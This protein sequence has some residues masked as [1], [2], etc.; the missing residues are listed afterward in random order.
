MKNIIYDNLVKS[1][2]EKRKQLAILV[3]PDKFDS[4]ESKS[5]LE[6]IPEETTHIFIG[7]ST[8]ANGQ[9][10]QT[11]NAFKEETS[12][13]IILFPGDYSQITKEADGI[14]FLSLLSGNNPEYLIGQQIKSIPKIINT[15]LQI[16]PTAYILIDGGKQSAVSK[17]TN[18]TAL[19]QDNIEQIVHTALAGEFL[20]YK[21]IYLEAGSGAINP[22]SA[23][24]ISAVK[25][26]ITIPLVVGGGIR[27]QSQKDQAF[28][29]GADMV[30]MGTI[31]E[32]RR[33]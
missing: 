28:I 16:L 26:I 29:A 14:L 5:F 10:E 27:S 9:T 7:G 12:L 18:T 11:V 15:S 31:Y 33:N 30:V 17:A 19:S 23:E 20:G 13:P 25:E 21:L 2:S 24:I 3:D 1:I 4:S 32:N 8:V 22:V 6:I